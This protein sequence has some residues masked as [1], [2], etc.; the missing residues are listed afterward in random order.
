M[1]ILQTGLLK[2]IP[3]QGNDEPKC[4]A[5]T[6]NMLLAHCLVYYLI[7]TTTA[8]KSFGLGLKCKP[9][10]QDITHGFA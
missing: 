4:L 1:K 2:G 10:T 7:G 9:H 5:Q 3:I 6:N 8:C